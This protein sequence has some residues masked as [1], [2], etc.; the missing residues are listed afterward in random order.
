MEE[1]EYTT[2]NKCARDKNPAKDHQEVNK[3]LHPENGEYKS[4]KCQSKHYSSK[5]NQ[6]QSYGIQNILY[7]LRILLCSTG[8]SSTRGVD[9]CLNAINVISDTGWQKN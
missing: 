3:T 7:A 1:K 5:D 2:Q 6:D 4:K 8:K 9:F